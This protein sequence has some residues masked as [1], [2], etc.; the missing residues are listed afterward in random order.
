MSRLSLIYWIG[1]HANSFLF[2]LNQ[3]RGLQTT[4]LP[5]VGAIGLVVDLLASQPC[6]PG[7]NPSP[8]KS[9][10]IAYQPSAS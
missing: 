1:G 6:G 3:H 2:H 4:D 5:V 8:A 7:S 10:I 9:H